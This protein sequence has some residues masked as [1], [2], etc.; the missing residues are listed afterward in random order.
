MLGPDD[1]ADLARGPAGASPLAP[2]SLAGCQA[3]PGTRLHHHKA[4]SSTTGKAARRPAP[5]T[6]TA[7]ASVR[8]TSCRSTRSR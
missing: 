2:T 4:A 6:S 5:S 7:S 8:W 3:A 1:L